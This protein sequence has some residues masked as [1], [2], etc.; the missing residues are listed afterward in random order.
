MGFTIATVRAERMVDEYPEDL[1]VY[2]LDNPVARAIITDSDGFT[3]IYLLGD[4]T[5]FGTSF[6]VMEEGYPSVYAVNYFT[7]ERL[8]FTL[9]DIRNRS[10]FRGFRPQE[11][12]QLRMELP[13]ARIDIRPMPEPAPP[14]LAAFS[15]ALVVTY[16]YRLPRPVS[17]Q[18]MQNLFA[19]LNNLNIAD[20]IEDFPLSL[21]PYGLDN[22]VRLFLETNS[23]SLD[24]L[25]GNQIET[26][27]Y[28]KLAG[29]PGVFTVN[30]LHRIILTRP[31]F[32][33]DRFPLLIIMSAIDSFSITG[34]ERPI[35]VDFHGEGE[36]MVFF[37]N[38]RK[39]ESRSFR[40]WYQNVAGLVFDAEIPAGSPGP[41]LPGTGAPG[42][43]EITIEF[44]L[45]DPPGERASI[46]L[47]PYNRDFYALR[48]E[49]AMEFLVARSQVR[50]IFETL[51]TVLFEE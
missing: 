19:P 6:F 12:I 25:I 23:A 13:T 27:H 10:L 2:G 3:A 20:F 5:P 51:D 7:A 42:T 29:A 39:A 31:F 35:S 1:S 43:G 17:H 36:D 46:T 40:A 34:G 28:A 9:D 4:R 8:R 30:G 32:I 11:L 33:I 22:P 38:G 49:G 15:P 45:N 41:A 26:G 21:S 48:Q 47:I 16:P 18:I 50:S 44:Q 37:I 24:L 14:H